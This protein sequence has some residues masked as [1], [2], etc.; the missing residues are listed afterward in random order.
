[1][2]IPWNVVS[3]DSTGEKHQCKKCGKAYSQKSR[4]MLIHT[5]QTLKCWNIPFPNQL[6]TAQ[7]FIAEDPSSIESASIIP[8]SDA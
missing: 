3:G 1:M 2:Y 7:L 5:G 8:V 6:L 4:L